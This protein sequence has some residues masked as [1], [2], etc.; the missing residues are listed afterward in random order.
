MCSLLDDLERAYWMGTEVCLLGGYGFQG[1]TFWVWMGR[2]KME[3]WGPGAA[4]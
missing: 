1:V 4:N 2:A 3:R